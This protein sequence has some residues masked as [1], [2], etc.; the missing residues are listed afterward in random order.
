MTKPFGSIRMDAEK[1]KGRKYTRPDPTT[2]EYHACRVMPFSVARLGVDGITLL[3]LV[4]ILPQRGADIK[5]ILGK[6]RKVV[7]E[8]IKELT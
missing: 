2:E 5:K 8:I 4:V 7:A 1:K 3:P 6:R